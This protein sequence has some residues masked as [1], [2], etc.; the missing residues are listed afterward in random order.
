MI[1]SRWVFLLLI[2][3]LGLSARGSLTTFDILVLNAE[4]LFDVDGDALFSDF[5]PDK[6]GPGQVLTKVRHIA[7]IVA[8]AGEGQGAEIILFQEFE[9]DQTPG[10]GRLDPESFLERYAAVPLVDMLREPLDP[11]IRNLPVEAFVL[12]ALAEAGLGPYDIRV[13]D[14]RADPTGRTIAHKNVVFSQLPIEESRTLPTDGA[15]GILEVVVL[16]GDSRLHL[17][18]NHWKSGA[19]DAELE[20]IRVGNA[21]VLRE[22]LDE[23]F[24]ADP[25]ADV[26]VGGDFNSQYDQKLRYPAMTRTAL[27]DELG[28][29]GNEAA[30]L[31]LKGPDLYN[32]WYE[33]SPDQRGSD[34][35]R[36]EWGTLMHLIVS[37]GLYERRGVTYIDNSFRVIRLPGRNADPVTGTPIRWHATRESGYGYTDHLPIAARFAFPEAPAP[38]WIDLTN[39]GTEE[40][41]PRVRPAVSP[42]QVGGLPESRR[43][44]D[45][46]LLG[47]SFRLK[48][49]VAA[50]NPLSVRRGDEVVAVWIP[51]P[52]LREQ[53]LSVWK[54]GEPVEIVATLGY[55][56]D[57]WQLVIESPDWILSEAAAAR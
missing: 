28:S 47:F 19:G 6:Y 22:R 24:A 16:A 35:Y 53:M 49:E 9:V 1:G 48:A 44:L 42:E 5:S 57:A 31:D 56:R 11:E 46:G 52:G 17:F 38:S 43:L 29:Q 18:N 51:N 7:E 30:M 41:T 25:L 4:H 54:P 45:T 36:N 39:P 8:A 32:L 2:S 20:K 55:Y 14:Y 23:I 15:R 34:T 37:R 12:K 27:N 10:P 13:S 26:V 3:L 50:L 33:L 40:L 21:R